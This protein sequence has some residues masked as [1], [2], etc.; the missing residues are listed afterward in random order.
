MRSS[1]FALAIFASHTG[2]TAQAVFDALHDGRIAGRGVLLVCNNP[3][4]PVLDRAAAA[5]IPTAVLNGRTHPDP[6]ELDIATLNAVQVAGATHILLA[7]YMKKL[8]PKTVAAFAGRVFNTHPALLPAFGGQGMYGDRVH[9][10]VLAAGVERTGAT[11]HRVTNDYD[12]GE[13]VRQ[14][15]VPV[16][17]GDD[18]GS[19]GERVRAAE[20]ELLV[21][22]LAATSRSEP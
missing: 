14:L 19:L 6:D 11:V 7:G 5:G 9:E 1:G 10:A 2:T 8:G 3:Q 4:A 16:L 15:E 22:V 20:R 21:A 12:A 18:V 17:P 13:I